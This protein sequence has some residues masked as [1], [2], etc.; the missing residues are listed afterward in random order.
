MIVLDID[1]V[2]GDFTQHFY[3]TIGHKGEH[4]DTYDCPVINKHW[5]KVTDNLEWWLGIPVLEYPPFAVDAY[6][7]ARTI[8]S[9]ITWL[10]LKQNNLPLAPVFSVHRSEE[11]LEV[12]RWL[13]P[14]LYVDDK[15]STFQML[16]DEPYEVY[17]RDHNYNRHIETKMRIKC[18]KE[19][20]H[21]SN[22]DWLLPSTLPWV[23]R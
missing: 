3:D 14:S 4:P 10:W 11:K 12:L 20:V 1:G 15:P 22:L 18:L 17:L 9:H 19:I 8:P 6:L 23:I 21:L 7:T 16:Q 5:H 13:K 2:V